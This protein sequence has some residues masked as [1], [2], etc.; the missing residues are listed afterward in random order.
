MTGLG[1][2]TDDVTGKGKG[3]SESRNSAPFSARIRMEYVRRGTIQ[4]TTDS[5]SL[6]EVQCEVQHGSEWNN[7]REVDLGRLRGRVN[8]ASQYFV[9]QL[10][11]YPQKL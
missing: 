6:M 2:V 10:E 8:F 1:Y 9:R 4:V 7:C 5:T 11:L 3:R